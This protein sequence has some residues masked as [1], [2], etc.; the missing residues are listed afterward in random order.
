LLEERKDKFK[1]HG[2]IC[3]VVSI[4]LLACFGALTAW[5]IYG[6]QAVKIAVGG[7]A[8]S[9]CGII[10]FMIIYLGFLTLIKRHLSKWKE[11]KERFPVSPEMME[12]IKKKRR[13]TSEIASLL[14]DFVKYEIKN[15][16][17]EIVNQCNEYLN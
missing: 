14:S 8:G 2:C 10:L 16:S 3:G 5:K 4:L 9:A 12:E 7:A 15:A 17:V 1:V 13:I 6:V 11:L